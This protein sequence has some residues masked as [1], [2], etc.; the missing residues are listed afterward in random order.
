MFEAGDLQAP[1]DSTF[2]LKQTA[3]ALAKS[4][5]GRARGKIVITVAE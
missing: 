1:I 5:A 3:Q 4:E 2:S